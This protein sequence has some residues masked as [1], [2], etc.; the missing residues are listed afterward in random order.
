[1]V[2]GCVES[3]TVTARLDT[4]GHRVGRTRLLTPPKPPAASSSDRPEHGRPSASDRKHG[5]ASAPIGLAELSGVRTRDGVS[6]CER[7]ARMRRTVPRLSIKPI[8]A[9]IVVLLLSCALCASMTMLVT[10]AL[11]YAAL[12]SQER[13][14]AAAHDEVA[15]NADD[16]ESS[17]ATSP[18][19]TPEPSSERL[20]A[21]PSTQETIPGLDAQGRVDLNAAS[22]AQLDGVTGIGPAIAQ[23][24]IDYRTANGPF[25]SVDQLLDV[26]GIGPKTLERMRDQVVVQ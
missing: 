8:H 21:E 15:D 13:A 5:D 26:S 17:G 10:Q 9:L 11:N 25:S 6:D 19:P 14:A 2:R 24:I 16:E 7:T 23:R 4:V 18:M 22:L 12:R 1:M 3:A 20:D